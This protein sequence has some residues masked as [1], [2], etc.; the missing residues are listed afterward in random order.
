MKVIL[1]QDVK[2]LGEEGDVKVVANG[3]ARNYLLPRELAVPYNEATVLMFEARKAEIEARKEQKRKDSASLKD[4]LQAEALT[5]VMPAGTNGKLYGAVTSQTVMELLQ[6]QGYDIERKR[7][8]I[9]GAAIKSTGKYTVTVR[10]YEA[11]TAELTVL[12]KSQEQAAKEA[13]E[14][15]AEPKAEAAEPAKAE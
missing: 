9:P 4:K 7:I 12:V 15:A 13:E 10:L 2:H 8:E 6:K 14:K 3:Y 1:N 5:I 11:N